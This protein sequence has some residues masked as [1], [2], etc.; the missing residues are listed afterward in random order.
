MSTAMDAVAGNLGNSMKSLPLRQIAEM[1]GL[2]A[3]K[4]A[5]LDKVD[6]SQ[7]MAITDPHWE[8]RMQLTMR[9]MFASMGDFFTTFEPELRESLAQAYANNY[10]LGE[11]REIDA[12]MSTPTGAKYAARSMTIMTDPA[13]MEATKSMMPRMMQQMPQFM[14]AAQKA[15]ASLPPPRK[16]QDLSDAEKEK[17]AKLLG[18]DPAK[19]HDPKNGK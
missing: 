11:L 14:A 13:V 15:T 4:A 16:V 3:A 1:G 19:L 2:D 17:I 5:A 6:L 12:F 7:V 18:I 8:E 10:S 9:A